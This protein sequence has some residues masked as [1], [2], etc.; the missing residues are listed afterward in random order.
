MLSARDP[1]AEAMEALRLIDDAGL[2]PSTLLVS[3][4][5][6]FKT[7]PSNTLPDGEA[8]IDDLVSALRRAGFAG[9]IGAGTPSYFTEFNRNPPGQAGDFVF[10]SVAGIVHA[11]DDISVAETLSVYPTLVESARALCPGKPVWLG[12]CTIGVRH[13]P[14]GSATQAQPVEPARALRHHR[15]ASDGALRRRLCGRGCRAGRI[16]RR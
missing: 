11:A 13:N 16:V 12:P 2:K 9:K 10:F 14:Y 8:P 5:R 1:D 6:E 15:P 3:P 7:R 4:R